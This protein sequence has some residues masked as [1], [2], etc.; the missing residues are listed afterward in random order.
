MKKDLS[1]ELQ[2]RIDRKAKPPGALGGLE[3]LALQIAQVQQS[4]QPRLVSPHVLV[5]AGDHGAAAQPGL[6]AYPQAITALMVQNF[7][8]GRAA[9]N[10]FTRQHGIALRVI[11]AGVAAALPPHPDLIQAKV[12]EGT[13]SYLEGPAMTEAQAQSCLQ[14]GADQVVALRSSG[15]NVLGLGEMGIGNTA[16]ASL[17]MACLLDLPLE[18]CVGRGTGLDEAGVA[19]KRTLLQQALDKQGRCQSPLE[20]LQRYGGFEIGMMVGAMQAATQAGMLLLV[21]G[22]IATAAYLLAERLLPSVK[23]YAIFTHQSDEAGHRLMLHALGAQP[24]LQLG[25]RLG[26]GTGCAL[27]YPLLVSAVAFL[28]EMGEL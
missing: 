12:A 25:L 7:L 2:S 9:I 26:E 22:F 28:N 13:Q 3:R 15:C 8:A 18:V 20:L 4:T 21:D 19:R 1:L 6:S 10:V 5:F 17:L 24:L 16:S 27:A 11:D 23:D 14:R